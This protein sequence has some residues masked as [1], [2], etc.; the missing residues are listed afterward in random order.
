LATPTF[1][2]TYTRACS[3][4][5]FA[6]LRYVLAGAEKLQQPVAGAFEEKFGVV[7]LEGYGCTEMSPVIAV[8]VENFEDGNVKQI[9]SKSGSVGRPIPGVS[10]KVVDP[11]TGATLPAN[12]EGL[13][14]VSGPNRMAGYLGQPGKTEEVFRDDWYVTGDMAALDE[15]G[16]IRITDRLSRFSKIGGEMVPHVRLEEAVQQIIGIHT[17]AVTAI[18]DER[19]GERLV[20]LH[21]CEEASARGIWEQLSQSTLP[22]LWV[23]K[24]ENIYRVSSIPALGTGKLDLRLVKALALKLATSNG[25]AIS[26]AKEAGS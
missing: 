1:L 16:F 22:K 13:L 3:R 15:D 5:Q 10:V 17:C 14:L 4:E 18:P 21:T 24:P 20:V 19:K 6:S 12:R 11:D 7:P 2:K 25:T 26:V 23:P 8:N 9:G